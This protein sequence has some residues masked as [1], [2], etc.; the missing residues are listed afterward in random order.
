MK[1]SEQPQP[2]TDE[3]LAWLRACKHPVY[4]EMVREIDRLRAEIDKLKAAR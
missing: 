2:M 4:Q 1:S 3:R